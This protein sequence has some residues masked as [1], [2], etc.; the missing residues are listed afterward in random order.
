[1]RELGLELLVDVL[2]GAAE[3]GEL[4]AGLLGDEQL[5]HAVPVDRLADLH[6]SVRSSCPPRRRPPMSCSN[7]RLPLMDGWGCRVRGGCWVLHFSWSG[8][9]WSAQ[10]GPPRA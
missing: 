8:P 1:V 6:R 3:G 2:E 4:P 5:G 7:S 9:F 10:D